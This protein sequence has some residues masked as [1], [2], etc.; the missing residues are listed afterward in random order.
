MKYPHIVK[1]STYGRVYQVEKG[2]FFPSVTT[3]LK[4]GLPTQE[5]LMKW[6]IETARGDYDRY[7]RHSGEASE[8]GTAVHLLAERVLAGEI[9]EI[10]DNPLDYVSGKGYYPTNSTLVQIRKGLQ[11]FMAFWNNNKPEIESVEQMMY[12][13]DQYEGSYMYP[14]A[15]RCDLVCTIK[16][17][18]WLIDIKTSKVVKDVL[19][20]QIQLSMYTAIHNQNNPKKQIDKMGILW[21]KKDFRGVNPPKSVLTPIEYQY[22]PD[23]I[24][25]VYTIFQEVYDGFELGKPKVKE[26][27]PKVFSLET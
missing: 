25:P 12:N 19:N 23:L 20:Y 26:P 10:S 6:M 8:I 24:K 18:R 13:T 22:R 14:F 21:A 7:I 11:S 15:G 3:V 16:G 1:G 9:V 17:E 2:L 4:Y 5:F 27:V